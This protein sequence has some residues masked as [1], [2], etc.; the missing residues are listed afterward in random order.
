LRLVTQIREIEILFFGPL[1]HIF[2]IVI[3]IGRRVIRIDGNELYAFR[4]KFI[5]QL[6]DSIFVRLNIRAMIA[7]KNNHQHRAIG[8]IFQAI[9]LIV[10]ALQ[11]F[12]VGR[13]RSGCH[14]YSVS[15]TH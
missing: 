12:E 3:G 15:H 13:Q 2:E 9:N 5:L 8:K 10:D 1:H 4:L 14:C 11:T 6:N 7:A